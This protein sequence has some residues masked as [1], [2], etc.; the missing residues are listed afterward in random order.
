PIM[1]TGRIPAVGVEYLRKMREFKF[2][3]T[4]YE[5]LL[6]QYELAKLDESKDAVLIQVVDKAV[7]PDKRFKPKRTL[8]V[9]VVTFSAFLVSIFLCLI[10]EFIENA[11]KNQDNSQKLEFLRDLLSFRGK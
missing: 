5:L 2:N 1:P 8:M 4:L 9:L 11:K 6:K 7:P 3:E 10:F